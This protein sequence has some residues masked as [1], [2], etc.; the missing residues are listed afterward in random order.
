MLFRVSDT[1]VGIPPEEASKLFEIFNPGN[2]I[3]YRLERILGRDFSDPSWMLSMAR[4]DARL[5][6]EE[7]GRGGQRLPTI[8]AI[9]S[10]MDEWIAK[11]HAADDWTVI[12]SDAVR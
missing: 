8:E 1:G 9:A 7:A 5:M 10:T 4:K 12:S 2:T 3:P 11:G 6:I